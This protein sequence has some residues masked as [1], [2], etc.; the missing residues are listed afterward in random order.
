MVRL[1]IM[2]PLELSEMQFSLFV[3]AEAARRWASGQRETDASE[4][5]LR[6]VGQITSAVLRDLIAQERPAERES[7]RAEKPISQANSTQNARHPPGDKNLL[8]RFYRNHAILRA[9]RLAERGARA[10][11][12]MREVGMRWPCRVAAWEHDPEKCE[13]VFR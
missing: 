13:S 2:P 10:V 8:F 11:V 4:R 12:T 3:A 1:G 5:T 7:P 9:S 6:G